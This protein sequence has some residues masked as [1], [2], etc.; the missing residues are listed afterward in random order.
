MIESIAFTFAPKNRPAAVKTIIRRFKTDQS[1]AEEG[2]ED[3]LRG[4]EKKPFP[5]VDGL[6]NA[7]RLMKLRTP[8]IG[9]LK[10]DTIIDSRIM[11][12]L[13]DGGFIDRAYAAQGVKSS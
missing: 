2:Y 5:S 9:D 7:Q 8:K 6:R 10:I 11:R 13:E 1:S 3:L 12:K 4:I